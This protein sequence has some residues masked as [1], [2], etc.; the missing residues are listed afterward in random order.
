M[1]K[2]NLNNTRIAVNSNLKFERHERNYFKSDFYMFTKN[3]S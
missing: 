3:V 1:R 2:N